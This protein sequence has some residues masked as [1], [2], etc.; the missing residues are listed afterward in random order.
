MVER[1]LTVGSSM[2][3]RPVALLVQTA[4]RFVSELHL[5]MDNKNINL[6]SIMGV[7]SIGTLAGNKVKITAEGRDESEACNTI[8]EFLS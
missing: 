6:K 2:L 3:E 8:A 7:I 4:G 5:Q 1:E